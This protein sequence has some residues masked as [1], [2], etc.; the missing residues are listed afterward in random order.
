MGEERHHVLTVPASY[1]H[2]CAA[3]SRYCVTV[4]CHRVLYFLDIHELTAARPLKTS[5]SLYVLIY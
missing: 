3:L 2:R 1:L 5:M 4:L